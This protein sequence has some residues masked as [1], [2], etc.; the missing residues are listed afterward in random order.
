MPTARILTFGE[1]RLDPGSGHLY[2]GDAIVAFALLQAL[3][4]QSGRL[5]SKQELLAEVWPGVF[6]G[7]A[8]LKGAIREVR[9]ALADDPHEPRFIETAH[10]RGYRF[11][12]PVTEAELPGAA[13]SAA[14]RISYARSG[15][16]NIAYQVIGSGPIDLVFVMGWVSHLE[17]FWN[18]P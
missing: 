14:P 3:A 4:R 15:N 9:K 1:F 16:V 18:E 12:A 8:V 17:Y 7:D 6:V 2:R 13:V 11:I 5:V 10:R